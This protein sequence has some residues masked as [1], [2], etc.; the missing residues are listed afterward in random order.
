MSMESSNNSQTGNAVMVMGE[1]CSDYF[2]R[3]S[4]ALLTTLDLFAEEQKIK[5]CH[6]IKIDVEGAEI[7][8]LQK[9]KFFIDRYWLN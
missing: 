2:E 3:N 6:L 8:F 9:N 4:M 7:V 1:I 5:K